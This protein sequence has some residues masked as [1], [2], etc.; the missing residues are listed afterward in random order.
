MSRHSRRSRSGL[1]AAAF[2]LVLALPAG[3]A[4]DAASL[5]EEGGLGAASMFG[6]LLYGPLKLV[7]A[8]GGLLVGGC[9]YV[10]SGGDND[11]AGPILD[12]SVRGDYVITPRHLSG[13]EDLEFIGR[14]PENRR[15]RERAPE[16][17]F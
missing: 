1:C 7:Y 3:A 16:S 17:G 4:T 11:V 6:S 13:E 10:F 8:L 9:A 2:A 5:A 15:A 12:A 14:S